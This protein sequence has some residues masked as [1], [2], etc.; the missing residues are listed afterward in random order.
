[1]M[2]IAKI[3]TDTRKLEVLQHGQKICMC[4]WSDTPDG[5]CSV[6][7]KHEASLLSQALHT[8]VD[9]CNAEKDFLPCEF[10]GH[11]FDLQG[12]GRYGCDRCNGEGLDDA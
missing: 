10:C 3:H 11:K 2:R 5:A 8:A 6:L 12:L 7:T 4:V 9:R 1:M